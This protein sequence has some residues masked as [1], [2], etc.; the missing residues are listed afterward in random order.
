M[1]PRKIPTLAELQATC[2][3]FNAICKEGDPVLVKIDGADKP[4]ATITTSEAVI[5]SGH[6]PVVWLR[7]VSGCYALTHVTPTP[8]AVV[9]EPIPTAPQ[10]AALTVAD[11]EEVLTDQRRLVR[12]LDVLLN[13]QDGAAKQASLCDIVAQVSGERVTIEPWSAAP[14]TVQG[15]YWHWNG[16]ADDAPSIVSVLFSGM[17][18]KCCVA[19]N[20]TPTGHANMCDTYGG[21]WKR[22][23]QPALPKVAQ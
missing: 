13:G 3:A 10:E 1:P 2:D 16:D 4:F 23:R 18:N 17:T 9:P 19:M 8:G 15:D 20:S 12:K 21:H 7:G 11:Y 22:I 5:L 6:T 14:P